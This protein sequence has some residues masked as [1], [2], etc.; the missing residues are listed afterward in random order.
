[1]LSILISRVM[2]KLH[3]LFPWPIEIVVTQI[4]TMK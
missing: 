1:M 3:V 2:L 4:K